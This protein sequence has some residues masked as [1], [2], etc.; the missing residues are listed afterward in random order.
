MNEIIAK[1]GLVCSECGAYL[2]TVNDSDTMR[3]ETSKKWSQMFNATIDPKSINCL[4]CQE[5]NEK[6][7]FGHCLVCGI[8]TCAA[9][10]GYESCAVCDEFGCEKLSMIW[11]HNEAAK[12]NLEKLRK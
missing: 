7:L 4:G 6:N 5:K 2:A 12:K 8:R 9:G 10:K 11:N 1:C 3:E